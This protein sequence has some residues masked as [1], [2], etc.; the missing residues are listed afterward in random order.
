M[1][2]QNLQSRLNKVFRD[3]SFTEKVRLLGSED[4]KEQI[5]FNFRIDQ[6]R[7]MISIGEWVP[8]YFVTVR[9]FDA[10]ERFKLIYNILGEKYLEN[11]FVTVVDIE[12]PIVEAL[13][14]FFDGDFMVRIKKIIVDLE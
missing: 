2:N 10:S 14:Q 11:N 1:D 6:I 5:E 12:K 7:K 3:V 4:T 9:I 13:E 8:V